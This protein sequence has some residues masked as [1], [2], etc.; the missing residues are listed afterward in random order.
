MKENITVAM[1]DEFQQH[2]RKQE[3]SQGTIAFGLCGDYD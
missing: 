1:Q 3:K 2:L